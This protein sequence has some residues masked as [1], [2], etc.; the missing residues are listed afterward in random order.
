MEVVKSSFSDRLLH[1]LSMQIAALMSD[2]LSLSMDEGADTVTLESNEE[3][4]DL[5]TAYR[6]LRRHISINPDTGK[7]YGAEEASRMMKGDLD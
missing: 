6:C 1:G 3:W 7:R 5:L 2:P 4:Q